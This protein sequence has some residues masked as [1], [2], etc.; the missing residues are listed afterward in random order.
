MVGL[1][2]KSLKVIEKSPLASNLG[3]D[4]A[5]EIAKELFEGKDDQRCAFGEETFQ[6]G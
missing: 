4:K 2:L 5:S 3:Y 6:R 1:K